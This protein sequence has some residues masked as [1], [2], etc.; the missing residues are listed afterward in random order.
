MHIGLDLSLKCTGAAIYD[1]SEL[2]ERVAISPPSSLSNPAKIAYIV[3][4]LLPLLGG[5]LEAVI[6]DV[7]LGMLGNVGMVKELCRLAGA[8]QQEWFLIS[9][10]DPTFYM[11]STAR[12]LVGIKGN[13]KKCEAQLF[14]VKKYALADQ[15]FISELNDT[16]ILCKSAKKKKELSKYQ[17]DKKLKILSEQIEEATGVGEDQADACILGLAYYYDMKDKGTLYE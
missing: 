6:E 3:E 8:V 17:F 13:C 16:V 12:K 10:K 9:K 2:V 11:A 14:V 15:R 7:F 5:V 4:R 1:G